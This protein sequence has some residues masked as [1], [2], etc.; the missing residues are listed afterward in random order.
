V[1]ILQSFQKAV[2]QYD[3]VR[4]FKEFAEARVTHANQNATSGTITFSSSYLSPPPSHFT[5]FSYISSWIADFYLL[6]LSG[7]YERSSAAT[8]TPS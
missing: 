5:T 2:E 3:C 6:V 1:N 7:P 8:P 4:Y